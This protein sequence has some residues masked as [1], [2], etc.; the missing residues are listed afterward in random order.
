ME[1]EK[2]QIIIDEMKKLGFILNPLIEKYH[3]FKIVINNCAETTYYFVKKE[4][5]EKGDSTK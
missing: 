4:G 1:N 5:S 3:S 2:Q